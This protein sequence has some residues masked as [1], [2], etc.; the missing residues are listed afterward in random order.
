M[1]SGILEIRDLL[2]MT[3]NIP[4]N[5]QITESQFY[6][7]YEPLRNS[8][9]IGLKASRSLNGICN[10]LIEDGKNEK[11]AI[12]NQEGGYSFIN[13]KDA[14]IQ[15]EFYSVIEHSSIAVK[16]HLPKLIKELYKLDIGFLFHKNKI[17]FNI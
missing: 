14:E 12:R 11:L 3:N 9:E 2:I 13:T 1:F 17:F 5:N 7:L 15:K 4:E 6:N 8:L 16:N 10:G